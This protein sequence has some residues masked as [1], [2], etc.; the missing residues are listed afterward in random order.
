MLGLGGRGKLSDVPEGGGVKTDIGSRGS[1]LGPL[2]RAP[3][4]GDGGTG[5]S[6]ELISV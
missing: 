6:D 2:R 3:T 4:P 5:G 1:D